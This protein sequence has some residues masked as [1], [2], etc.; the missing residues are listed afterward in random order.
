MSAIAITAAISLV[1]AGV[2]GNA[3]LESNYPL[4]M[5]H[6]RCIESEARQL[7]PSG[8]RA[9][10]VATAAIS[11]CT[12]AEK[13]LHDAVTSCGGTG[14]ADDVVAGFIKRGRE[15]AIEIVVEIRARRH[16]RAK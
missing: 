12:Q 1:A 11:A 9:D 4:G 5:A 2:P 6:R 14:L 3:C 7:E 8:D 15:K 16:S 10:D 13:A